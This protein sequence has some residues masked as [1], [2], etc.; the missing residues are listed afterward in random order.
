VADVEREAADLLGFDQRR[1]H[2]LFYAS[3]STPAQLRA[4]VEDEIGPWRVTPE[5]EALE[6]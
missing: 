3:I 6:A 4:L 5:T 1:A 2:R